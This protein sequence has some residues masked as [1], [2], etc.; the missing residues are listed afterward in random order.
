MQRRNSALDQ[1]VR[2]SL[3]V[4]GW[5][6]QRNAP[7]ADGDRFSAAHSLDLGGGEPST[8]NPPSVE[9]F[10]YVSRGV[11]ESLRGIENAWGGLDAK[12]NALLRTQGQ[13]YQHGYRVKKGQSSKLI[14]LIAGFVERN[15]DLRALGVCG[16]WARGNPTPDSDLDLVIIARNPSVYRRR[17]QWVRELPFDRYG[18]NYVNH[19]TATYGVVWSAHVELEPYAELELS[20][21]AP[22][23]ACV[24]PL[25]PG[26]RHV[27]TD[28]FKVVVDKDRLLAQLVV[29]CSQE[30]L[31]R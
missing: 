4:G 31:A 3:S 2:A 5:D 22:S 11:S 10:F 18:F 23:W 25:D 21:A 7:N 19:H 17:Q 30:V 9:G 26:T 28:G 29:A 12:F 27:V 20:F 13:R 15:D 6:A 16:S 24:D 14:K 8:E 1:I